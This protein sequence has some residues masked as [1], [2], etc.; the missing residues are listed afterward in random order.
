[1]RLLILT[2]NTGEGHNSAAGALQEEAQRRGHEAEI[3]DPLSLGTEHVGELAGAIYNRMIQ[4]VPELFGLIYRAGDVYSSTGMR[5]PVYLANARHAG[6]L[7]EY[8]E[9]R[10]ID[11]VIS[12]HLYGMEVVTAARRQ[13][14]LSIPTSGV[15]T[16]YTCIPFLGETGMDRYFIPHEDLREE[17]RR[18][19]IPDER[20]LGCGIPVKRK[21]TQPIGKE[22]ARNRLVLPR[23]GRIYL[24][25]TGGMGSGNAGTLCRELLREETQPFTAIVLAGR[26]SALRE[27][28]EKAFAGEQRIRCVCFTDEVNLYMEAADVILSKPGGLSSTETAALGVPL[29]HT[30]A[31]PGCETRNAV[32]F[33]ERGMSVK[34]SGARLAVSAAIGLAS[35]PDAAEAMRQAQRTQIHADAAQRILQAVEEQ[36]RDRQASLN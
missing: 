20:I 17:M 28:M 13:G 36:V 12:T 8:A 29:V 32:F 21:F 31:I 23:E 25:M 24:L 11:A 6:R 9:E 14:L 1:M 5:S 33:S 19:G 34:A 10:K 4:K 18:H 35:H 7:S 3:V 15:L 16:D 22:Q 27:E 2:C 30:M 26:N